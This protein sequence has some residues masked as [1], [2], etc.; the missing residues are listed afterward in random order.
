MGYI[1]SSFSMKGGIGKSTFVWNAAWRLHQ[2][3]HKVL[4]CEGDSRAQSLSTTY[5]SLPEEV[6]KAAPDITVYDA[7]LEQMLLDR[8]APAYD[9]V[10]IDTKGGAD[11]ENAA[12]AVKISD[13]IVS[14]LIPTPV[15]MTSL[16]ASIR[17]FRDLKRWNPNVEF[18]FLLCAINESKAIAR[19]AL[20]LQ[21]TGKAPFFDTV[22][23]QSAALENTLG[24]HGGP[25][26]SF[27]NLAGFNRAN[28]ELSQL[29]REI[30]ILAQR[31]QR[32]E[33]QSTDAEGESPESLPSEHRYA[34]PR[35]C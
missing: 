35:G 34:M 21:R 27:A 2:A 12:S 24:E 9:F 30:L 23:H 16:E 11:D 8:F 7:K 28:L 22:L 3:G 18:R 19:E 29:A 6:R 17:H 15:N 10:F 1:I 25:L 5:S 26:T 32:L 31:R 20:E 33:Q 4:M 14:T 13:L